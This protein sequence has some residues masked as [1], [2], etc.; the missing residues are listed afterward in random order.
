MCADMQT[1]VPQYVQIGILVGVHADVG[2]HEYVLV[3]V[4]V[5]THMWQG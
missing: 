5:R 1:H 3:Y 4:H 2:A